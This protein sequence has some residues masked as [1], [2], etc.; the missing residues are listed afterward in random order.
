[1]EEEDEEEIGVQRYR[2]RFAYSC[3]Y[4]QKLNIIYLGFYRNK[5]SRYQKQCSAACKVLQKRNWVLLF[6]KNVFTN[7]GMRLLPSD[8]QTTRTWCGG[9]DKKKGFCHSSRHE[10]KVKLSHSLTVRFTVNCNSNAIS[11]FVRLVS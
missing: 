5:L 4:F 6:Y 1:V 10:G 8:N 11:Y 3:A 2:P 7:Y 9:H